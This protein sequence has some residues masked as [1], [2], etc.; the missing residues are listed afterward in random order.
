M[1]E[2][3]PVAFRQE[4]EA[5]LRRY[6]RTTLPISERFPSVR[7]RFHDLLERERFVRGPYVESLPDFVKGCTLAHLVDE[8]VLHPE[9]SRLDP[10]LLH[11]RLHA[12]QE[13]AIRIAP[14]HDFVVATGTGSGK[15]ECF[16]L[17]AIDHLLRDPEQDRPGVRM[18]LL[19]PLNA[20]ANDQLY[21]RIAPL[22]L[23]HLPG[24]GITFGRFTSAVAANAKREEIEQQLLRNRALYEALGEPDEI[25]P[26]WLLTREEMLERPP[27]ILITNYA[28]LEHIL[29]LPRNTPLFD[30]VR[31]SMVVMDEIHTYQGA[32]AMEVA[33]L[34]RK[35]RNRLGIPPERVRHIGTSA[36]LGTSEDARSA[37]CRFASDLMGA[38]VERIVTGKRQS[39]PALRR[40][41]AEWS[42]PASQ[43]VRLHELASR[44]LEIGGDASDRDMDT[45]RREAWERWT[46]DVANLP[47]LP[48]EPRRFGAAMVE[49]FGANAE[50][51]RVAQEL[52]RGVQPFREL[53]AAVFGEDA[54]RER[55][56]AGLVAV[57]L[58]C[59]PGPDSFPLLPAR[60]HFIVTGLESAAVRLDPAAPERVAELVQG[61]GG[62]S[63]RAPMFPLLTCRNCGE[64]YIEAYEAGRR[65]YGRP[66]E[67]RRAER[68]LYRLAP[69]QHLQSVDEEADSG[70]SSDGSP[71][72]YPSIA[73][74]DT[75][76]GE[77]SEC[78]TPESIQLVEVPLALDEERERRLVAGRRCPACGYR[79]TRFE[80]PMAPLATANDQM[81]AL[82]AQILL[83][84]LPPATGEARR[85]PM[86]GRR[87]L[88]FHDN[89][90]DAAFF[91]PHFERTTR[92]LAIRTAII[93]ALD[94]NGERLSLPR[95]ADEVY[96]ILTA[97][98]RR[99][100][101]FFRALDREEMDATEVRRELR[102]RIT[103]EMCG[104]GA[105]RLSLEGL[106][107]AS[108]EL[109]PETFSA[110]CSK[111]GP[112]LP[113]NISDDL[114]NLIPALLAPLRAARI[115]SDIPHVGRDEERI[116]G[117]HSGV[118]RIEKIRTKPGDTGV[119]WLPAPN[120]DNRRLEL[121]RKAY[122]LD[123]QE[124]REILDHTWKALTHPNVAIL[125]RGGTY[126][127][128]RGFVLNLER[129]RLTDARTPPLYQCQRC[130]L[131]QLHAPG[132]RCTAYRC[133][134]RVRPLD[135]QD[136]QRFLDEN[137][138]AWLY[139]RGRGLVANA[140]EHTAALAI[141]ARERIE[142][143]FRDGKVNLLSCTT[144]MEL[145]VDLGELLAVLNANVPPTIANY[146]QR[147]GRA[148]RR[149]QAAPIVLTF[150]RNAVYDQAVFK[151]FARW[152]GESPRPPV[153]QLVN[154][155]FF[156]R[157]Q[158]S[159][160]LRYL[161]RELLGPRPRN[162]PVLA[163][164][165]GESHSS[166][167]FEQLWH[168]IEE[169][170]KESSEPAVREAESLAE[171]SD[172][173]PSIVLR[174]P[175]LLERFRRRMKRFLDGHRSRL[176]RLEGAMRDYA[177][178]EQ[179]SKASRMKQR[180]DL[181]CNQRVVDLLVAESLIPSY[182]FPTDVVRLEVMSTP[183]R[184]PR[185]RFAAAGRDLDLTRDA[186]LGISE[187]A[188]GAEVV[189]GGRVWTSCGIAR[190]SE[191]YEEQGW[192][193]LCEECN[194][195][196]IHDLKE[197]VPECCSA[198]GAPLR[199]SA[200]RYLQPLGFLTSAEEP[201]GREVGP[202]RR[203]ARAAGEV[204]LVTT[205]P[206][207]LFRPTGV[208]GVRIAFLPGSGSGGE[209]LRGELFQ[210]NRGRNGRGFL[211]CPSCEFARPPAPKEGN[212]VMGSAARHKNPRTGE[213]CSSERLGQPVHLGYLFP[214]DVRVIRFDA[215]LPSWDN[216][217][218]PSAKREAF[219]RT[220]VEAIRI[221]AARRLE[222][223]LR[224]LHG[225][226]RRGPTGVDVVLYDT[227]GGGAGFAQRI[228][229]ELSMTGLLADVEER[230]A[231]NS[232][233]ESVC[234]RCLL[235]YTNQ[236]WW[237]VLD[238]KPVL[239]WFRGCVLPAASG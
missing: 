127:G 116:W 22:L 205:P 89:R 132:G 85:R 183:G 212:Q 19:Y 239:S 90:Q 209:G 108:L 142:D 32:Q 137:H 226:W 105:R 175:E 146:Q 65:L 44:I 54:D 149:A 78:E 147:T 100:P 148:G 204:R 220:L 69:P 16:L 111:L 6:M 188:P 144:T 11:R 56:L 70:D 141:E 122:R 97:N 235:D 178:R 213:S 75:A 195:P 182:A 228:G 102:A 110:L 10:D 169:W 60:Y 112:L 159:I 25:D 234:R 177:S 162:A 158:F 163:D 80:E 24:T 140:R 96:Q 68:R 238:R 194:H 43:W 229:E 113:T 168:R 237:D 39:H 91:A 62:Q 172:I 128:D 208:E 223:D 161:L 45:A 20:L 174:G 193:R 121:L 40:E 4:L 180:I 191:E 219:I 218:D 2:L 92:N 198:C 28:M 124:A 51:R 95:T 200:R 86:D 185:A 71:P 34:L 155:P 106:G 49:L 35:L 181:Y 14:H 103:A 26:S 135:P 171:G 152:L 217:E 232:E 139:L 216:E 203:R 36:S 41:R 130:G 192:Y 114:E 187:F 143:H 104:L 214:T 66:N 202:V 72:E 101:L 17:P 120:S 74:V 227:V 30:P 173:D 131:R 207:E 151:D 150:A 8:G 5:V 225:T 165:L 123:N 99:K 126:A 133:D 184:T 42:L 58:L 1:S 15:T 154:E 215:P 61:R 201:E 84:A 199:G 134:G 47:F 153:V 118:R 9:W 76:T 64:P 160:L 94:Q 79:E 136:R 46:A 210:L 233:C 145:G 231:C 109:D 115:I 224:D 176:E 230:L 125:V 31:L 221:S 190:Y 167:A 197:F 52:E 7:R 170:L 18:L 107:L 119:F 38:R 157:H 23:K 98:G 138:Y 222:C 189:A 156:H 166:A 179:Y 236:G 196:E 164:L 57:G 63:G 87:L 27:H 48:D 206:A 59:R 186:I 3:D 81:S 88:V 67:A 12:H 129:F 82:L 211:R 73:I 55:A 93:R 21:F 13:E 117:P 33:F 50:M 83:E 77:L 37:A 29:L 53:A